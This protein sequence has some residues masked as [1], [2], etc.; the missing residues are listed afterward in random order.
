MSYFGMFLRH[1]E[2][3]CLTRVVKTLKITEKKGKKNLNDMRA[4][5]WVDKEEKKCE[6]KPQKNTI[7]K[8]IKWKSCSCFVTTKYQLDKF[9]Q[10]GMDFNNLDT[11]N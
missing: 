8:M 11:K 2:M 9:T 1:I 10:I 4:Q 3:S 5:Y 6:Q 7:C